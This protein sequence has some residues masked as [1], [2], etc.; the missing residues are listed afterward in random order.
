VRSAGTIDDARSFLEHARGRTPES[1]VLA[2]AD[3]ALTLIARLANARDTTGASLFLAAEVA[4]DRVGAPSLARMLFLRAARD[5]PASSLAPKALLAAADA[6]PDSAK[7]W[8]AAVRA[9]YAESPYAEL[10]DGKAVPS[11]RLERDERLLRQTWAHATM[12]RD[13][14][15]VATQRSRP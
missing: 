14:A 2:R 9:R 11:A 12:I 7:S 13:S 1:L 10:L 6:S 5:Y 15:S 3:T 4:R 8:R